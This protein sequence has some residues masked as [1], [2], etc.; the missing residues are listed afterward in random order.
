MVTASDLHLHVPRA[1]PDT[2]RVISISTM[3]SCFQMISFRF[4][5]VMVE[6][7]RRAGSL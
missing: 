7:N 2:V 6:G 5:L 4:H 1:N 3:I